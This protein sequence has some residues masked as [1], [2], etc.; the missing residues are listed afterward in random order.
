MLAGLMLGS[1]AVAWAIIM[2]VTRPDDPT[3]LAER[4]YKISEQQLDD[5]SKSMS[6]ANSFL[7]W[8]RFSQGLPANVKP[9]AELEI[10]REANRAYHFRLSLALS[11]ATACLL[12]AVAMRF[13]PSARGSANSEKSV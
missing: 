9:P 2:F 13:W 3:A 5:Q 6:L 12:L 7:W 1:A 11:L 4:M 8:E 10:L